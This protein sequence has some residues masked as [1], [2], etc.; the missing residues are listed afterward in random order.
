MAG[1]NLMGTLF[2]WFFCPNMFLT[3][4]TLVATVQAFIAGAA[5]HHDMATNVT[6]RRI[7]LHTLG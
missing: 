7:T 3:A 4:T 6:G 2:I 1:M 5:A